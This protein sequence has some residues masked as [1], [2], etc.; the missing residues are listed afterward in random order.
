MSEGAP[1]EREKE[2][3]DILSDLDTI[4][5]SAIGSAPSKEAPKEEPKPEPSPPPKPEPKAE[6]ARIE[7]PPI[8]P[9]EPPAPKEP[10]KAAPPP[11]PA[12]AA[13]PEVELGARSLPPAAKPA[14]PKAETPKEAAPAIQAPPAAKPAPKQSPVGGILGGEPPANVPKEQVRRIAFLYAPG[15]KE[16]FEKFAA[17]VAEVALKVSKKPI[18]IHPAFVLELQPAADPAAVLQRVKEAGAVGCLAVLQGLKDSFIRDVEDAFSAEDFFLRVVDP[19][20]AS[21]RAA[22][23]DLVVDMM[24]LRAG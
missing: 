24:L 16:D 10:P 7:L 21:K 12:P 17:F 23:I 11:K 9:P 5:K 19:A 1:E 2:I 8:K 18:H 22:A 20:E 6:S 4:L 14:E 15:R 3:Q 13:A